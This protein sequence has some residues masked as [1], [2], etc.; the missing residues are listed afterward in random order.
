[1]QGTADEA[2]YQAGS[3]TIPWDL[4]LQSIPCHPI[5]YLA[6]NVENEDDTWCSRL[7]LAWKAQSDSIQLSTIRQLGQYL[8]ERQCGERKCQVTGTALVFGETREFEEE[9]CFFQVKDW[10][11]HPQRLGHV[12]GSWIQV[13]PAANVPK[14]VSERVVA[15]PTAMK[16][17]PPPSVWEESSLLLTR[18][19]RLSARRYTIQSMIKTEERGVGPKLVD[20][21][22]PPRSI[23]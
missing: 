17:Y 22:N 4:T 16:I 15:G 19:R 12:L 20:P 9:Y 23:R 1:M 8:Y 21:M 14:L 13:D 10:R 7:G 2:A 18:I 6:R 11:Q 5:E 3:S